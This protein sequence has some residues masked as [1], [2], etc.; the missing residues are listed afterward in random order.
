MVVYDTL[1]LSLLLRAAMV[2]R[3]HWV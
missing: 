2:G 1:P 3:L